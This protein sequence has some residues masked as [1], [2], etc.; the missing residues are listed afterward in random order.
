MADNSSY[1]VHDAQA[2]A[3]TVASNA[4]VAI[5]SVTDLVNADNAAS[6]SVS[7][8]GNTGDAISVVVSDGTNSTSAYNTTVDANGNW[9][10]SGIDV[11]AL[12]DGALTYTATATNTASETAQ[13][14]AAA[15]K[16]T[17]AP[18]LAITSI[19]DPIN[20]GNATTVS[21]AGTGEIGATITVTVSDGTNT[22]T[23]Y[24]ATVGQDGTWTISGIDASSLADGSVDF[25][26]VAGDDA[27]NT[28]AQTD[29]ATKDTQA[30]SL[31]IS[32]VTDPIT[33]AN[34][35]ST[36]ING[37]GEVGS[38]IS[39]IATDGTHSTSAVTTT[40]GENGTWTI[41]GIDV[42]SL[43]DGTIAYQATAS[44]T[45]GNETTDTIT[46]AK[47]AVAITLVTDPVNAGNASNASVSGTGVVGATVAVVVSDGTNSTTAYTTTVAENG[48]WS[49][50]G[51]DTSALADGTLTFTATATDSQENSAQ[52]V[53]T[54]TKDTVAPAV[55]ISQATDP[56]NEANSGDA[57]IS[58]TG[59]AGGTISVVVSDGTHSTTAATVIVADDGTWSIS[60]IDL[61][62][63]D[64]GTI[65]Y[66]VTATDTAGNESQA[67]L[68]ATKDTVAPSVS[69]SNATDPVQL[70]NANQ[71]SVDG[72]GEVGATISVVITDGTG[73]TTAVTTTVGSDGTWSL[74]AIDVSS[75]AD[76]TITYQVTATDAAGNATAVTQTATK[77]TIYVSVVTDPINAANETGVTASGT[78]QAG[79]TVTVVATDGTNSTTNYTTTIASDGTWS[80]SGID[81]SSLADG[82]ITVTATASDG[83]NSA[84]S[85]KTTTKDATAPT[86]AITSV[87]TSIDA[88]NASNT[89]ASGTGEAGTT[90]TLVV[91]DGT[92]TTTTYTANVASDGTWSIS[93][94]DVSA[95]ADGSLTYTATAEDAAGNT[96]QSSQTATKTAVADGSLAGVVYVDLN[97]SGAQDNSEPGL[98]GI[99]VTLSGVDAQGNPVPS[100]TTTTASDGSYS[101]SNLVAGTYSITKAQPSML[102]SGSSTAGTLGGTATTNSITG[103]AIS[104]GENGTNYNFYESGLDPAMIS[105]RLFLASTPP[106]D[107]LFSDIVTHYGVMAPVVTSIAK[108]D[109]DPTS[110]TT[111][112]YTVVFNESVTGVDASSFTVLGGTGASIA[113][114]T[115][116]GDTYVVTV[117]VGTGSGSIMLKLVDSD[118]IASTSGT[119][120]GGTGTGNGDFVGP[121]YT[122]ASGSVNVTIGAATDPINADNET[123]ILANGTGDAGDAIS[124]VVGDGTNTTQAYTATVDSS[125][126]WSITG[127]DV[128]SLSD[129]TLTFT[130][131]ATASDGSGNTAQATFTATK[132]TVA[133]T[134]NVSAATDPINSDNAASVT[135]SGTGEAGATISLV[136]GDGTTTT[137]A[138]TGTVASDGTW[139]IT[140]IDA[141]ALTDGTITFTATATD[142]AG[143]T[144]EATITATKDATVPAVEVTDVTDP[145][146]IADYQSASAS[147]TGEIGATISLVVT[148]GTNTTTTYTT[149]VGTDGTWT[150]SGI[151]T[152]GLADGTVTYTA[153]ASDTA[154]NTS[155]SSKTATK[156]TVSVSSVTDPVNAENASTVTV[157]GTGEVGAT[158]SLVAS[159]GTTTTQTYTTTVAADGT[160]TISD[161]DTSTLAD[162]TITFTATASDDQQNSAAVSLTATKDTVAPEGAITGVTDPIN[163][164]NDMSVTATGTGEVGASVK[165]VVT[166]GTNTTTEYKTTVG[167]TARGRS[168]TSTSA[169]W[170]TARS[171]STSRLPMPPAT[172]PRRTLR[173]RR[174]RPCR[175][176]K[177]RRSARSRSPITSRS[178]S[179]ARAKRGPRS[180]WS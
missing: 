1:D 28:T 24:Q 144:A 17:Q 166:D 14:T 16:D 123:S 55:Q 137:Q 173:L 27:G 155:Q 52:S 4:Q 176:W 148:D 10:I 100:Q 114:V 12:N 151:D 25:N 120:L 47:N 141:S 34:V 126:L 180:L 29:P 122:L 135:V 174:T 9:T 5:S 133:P 105:I 139:T 64:D 81:T 112:G 107:Q 60:G 45:A 70:S 86:V 110:A 178:L 140:G 154:G 58:G 56:A 153:T 11:T 170:P 72:T 62:S 57:A 179:A 118:T 67:S 121:A 78:G 99:I 164:Q 80:V 132:D 172:R 85:S 90:I 158:I 6:T 175:R 41:D 53:R 43:N 113:S 51:I 87:T 130:V 102:T 91:T 37:T 146:T 15:T 88:Y 76:G 143:N 22:T 96:A 145:L 2:F 98:A 39:V 169:A 75:L 46:A 101:F 160:W 49:I 162:G 115:G 161:I 134:V 104:S 147:G 40:V 73:S 108:N 136:A 149:T 150:I 59:E 74:T 111:V 127:I 69:I 165:L 177:S 95:L 131:T 20:G 138:Y 21:V 54:V 152:S 68:D 157:S 84:Q 97:H 8:T 171:R 26:I 163:S 124:L 3:L 89:T 30:P 168:P 35:A 31:A 48:T 119:P 94:I 159:D 93:G 7:G 18:A 116:S 33:L 66:Q 61:S 92:N 36:S 109:A 23:Q 65:T 71:V 77:D 79:A 129:G 106:A 50:D 117:N 38:T 42:S 156:T 128:S 63:L 44:D 82:T 13:A 19:T 103:I 142:A 125:G 32:G 83:T 167:R